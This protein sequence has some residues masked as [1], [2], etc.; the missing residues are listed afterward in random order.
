MNGIDRNEVSWVKIARARFA[1]GITYGEII[2]KSLLV[3]NTDTIFNTSIISI[4][5]FSINYCI[6]RL[7]VS[8]QK[9]HAV[10]NILQQHIKHHIIT[11]IMLKYLSLI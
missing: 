11:Y 1:F 8:T 5:V 10:E 2:V 9:P 6:S 3:K 7:A 4:L